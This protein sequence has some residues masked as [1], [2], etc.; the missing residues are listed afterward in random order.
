MLAKGDLLCSAGPTRSPLRRSLSLSWR[1]PAS[2]PTRSGPFSRKPTS[3]TMLVDDHRI[4]HSSFID[5][6]HPE[7]KGGRRVMKC[8]EVAI[9]L[10]LHR[11]VP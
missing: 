5:K 4:Q 2:I 8:A 1:R 10:A 11:S 9:T 7:Y 3:E 6:S